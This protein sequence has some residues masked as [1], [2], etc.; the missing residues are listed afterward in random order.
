[1]SKVKITKED[2]AWEIIRQNT[3]VKINVH[4]FWVIISKPRL[5]QGL[6]YK[7][8]HNLLIL[9]VTYTSFLSQGKWQ[10]RQKIQF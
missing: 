10:H 2:G 9:L 6:L 3:K 1:M 5:S 7:H 8:R 4:F